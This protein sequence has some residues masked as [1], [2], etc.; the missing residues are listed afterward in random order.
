MI[1]IKGITFQT[2]LKG[3]IVLDFSDKI[4]IGGI[5]VAAVVVAGSI[6]AWKWHRRVSWSQEAADAAYE[7]MLDA[8]NTAIADFPADV[9]QA[10][11]AYKTAVMIIRDL[12]KEVYGEFPEFAEWAKRFDATHENQIVG[13]RTV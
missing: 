11:L 6:A 10:T 5:A 9:N 13:L 3:F 1:F 2:Y 8:Y 4:V 12:F 7:D